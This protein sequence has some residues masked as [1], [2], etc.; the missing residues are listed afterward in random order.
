MITR[1][2]NIDNGG[3]GGGGGG[4]RRLPKGREVLSGGCTVVTAFLS[5]ATQYQT[6]YLSA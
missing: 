6:L 4:G 3:G 1:F 2:Y 5:V